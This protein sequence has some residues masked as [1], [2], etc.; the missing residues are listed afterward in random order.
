M[1]D[2]TMCSGKNCP[3]AKTCYRA[4]AKADKYQSYFMTPPYNHEAEECEY[5][6]AARDVP[7]KEKSL[8]REKK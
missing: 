5:Y 3:L 7:R 6:W 8:P 4:Q 1:P 2:I